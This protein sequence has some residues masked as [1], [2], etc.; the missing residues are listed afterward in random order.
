MITMSPAE[1]RREAEF[2]DLL[3][4]R[5][6]DPDHE[7]AD[8]AALGNSLHAVPAPPDAVFRNRLREQLVTEARLRAELPG[9]RAKA[10]HAPSSDQPPARRRVPQAAAATCA[11]ALVVG[12]GTAVA[13]TGA[14]PG[15]SLYELKRGLEAVELTLARSDA[16]RGRELMEQ[17]AERIHEAEQLATSKDARDPRI[18]QRTGVVIA[19]ADAAAHAGSSA[20]LDAYQKNGDLAALETLTE[21]AAQ[22]NAD[23][24]VLIPLLD[25]TLRDDAG[26]LADFLG[27][28]EAGARMLV[29]ASSGTPEDG[30]PLALDGWATTLLQQLRTEAAVGEEGVTAVRGRVISAPNSSIPSAPGAAGPT[31]GGPGGLGGVLGGVTGGNGPLGGTGGS[32]GGGTG[33]GSLPTVPVPGT[34]GS[35]PTTGT[36]TTTSPPP[37]AS[38]PPASTE[39]PVDTGTPSTDVETTPPPG[40]PTPVESTTPEGAASITED[41][42]GTVTDTVCG[43]L[44][45]GPVC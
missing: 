1:R 8:L 27:S 23:L 31:A 11:A 2:A 29:D 44:P 36:P 5:L 41:P 32:T 19:E 6:V 35:L 3:E 38:N 22:Q 14:V 45:P 13:S 42:V 18:V 24:V 40:T 20:L 16:A 37:T 17:A 15:D 33:G 10:T 43:L 34:G 30:R 25:P 9:Q 21:T 7:L 4:G 12:F 26:L 39:P 28:L